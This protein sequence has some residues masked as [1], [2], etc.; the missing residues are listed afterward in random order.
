[1]PGGSSDSGP[2]KEALTF[3]VFSLNIECEKGRRKMADQLHSRTTVTLSSPNPAVEM[4][5]DVRR[6]RMTEQQRAIVYKLFS[7]NPVAEV[8]PEDH[9]HAEETGKKGPAS[10]YL[11][12][13]EFESIRQLGVRLGT[14][15]VIAMTACD[16]CLHCVKL[17]AMPDLGRP[18]E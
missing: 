10:R 11:T 8:A 9:S 7:Q 17:E 4:Q 6:L 2:Q 15:G 14:S 12:R 16:F 3:A 18:M 13:D 5:F 1:M